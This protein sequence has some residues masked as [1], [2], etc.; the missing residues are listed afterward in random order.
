MVDKMLECIAI[1][2][3]KLELLKPMQTDVF[4]NIFQNIKMHLAQIGTME[5]G[6][7]LQKHLSLRVFRICFNS[8]REDIR[9]AL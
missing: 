9:L 8:I 5:I 2:I 1:A 6:R 7:N 3:L 4:M